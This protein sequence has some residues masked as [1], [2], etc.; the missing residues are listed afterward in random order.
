MGN[1]KNDMDENFFGTPIDWKPPLI[2]E[3]SKD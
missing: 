2:I 1:P 3:I